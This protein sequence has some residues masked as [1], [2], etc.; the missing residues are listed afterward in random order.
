MNRLWKVL[1][2]SVLT[3]AS[4]GQVFAAPGAVY[5]MTNAPAGN[6]VV[7]FSRSANGALAPQGSFATGG[8]GSGAGL[9]SQGSVIVSDDHRLLFA[10]NAGSATVSSFRIEP[11]GLTLVDQVSSGG[12]L[13]I[14]ATY[15]HGLLYVLNA[16]SPNSVAGFRVSAK[17]AITA[18]AGSTR[19]LSAAQAAPAQVGFSDDGDTLIVT[20]KA[21]NNVITFVVGDEGLLEGPFVHPSSGPTPF[22]FAVNRQD[23][24]LVSEAGA[25]GGASTYRV[26]GD[27]VDPVSAAINTGQQ[28][29][30]WA[31]I[32]TDGRYGYVANTGSG[33]V[34]GFAIAADG[35]ASQLDADGVSATTGGNPADMA[36]S[37]DGGYLY[38][39]VGV[40]NQI[41][42]LQVQKG[43]ALA[44]IGQ[45]AI[46]ANAVGLAGF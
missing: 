26:D 42:I 32:T 7:A 17:G 13:P 19:P 6:E 5:V 29:A 44:P 15:R 9:G 21:T 34:T 8:L 39:R 30:C 25:G 36:L 18:L 16:G 38:V 27:A 28:A 31:V 43:G 11:D 10:V 1:F 41:A 46:P 24:L 33:T 20:E 37:Q 40:A 2:A 12:P 35:S 23:T 22:G 14:S 4:G 45:P 3:L